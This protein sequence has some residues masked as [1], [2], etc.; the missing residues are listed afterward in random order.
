M[1]VNQVSSLSRI[2]NK[3]EA[4]DFLRNTLKS[5][6]PVAIWRLPNQN[7]VHALIDLSLE[8]CV[9]DSELESI[10]QSFI[11][12]SYHDSHPTKAIV[13]KGHILISISENEAQSE[14]S[15]TL[16]DTQIER[17]EKALNHTVL[18]TTH[19]LKDGNHPDFEHMVADAV[20]KIKDGSL[21]KVVLSRY[22]DFKLKESF[23]PISTFID[24]TETYA[25]AFCHLTSTKS[26]G[27]WLGASPEKLIAIESDQYFSTDALAGTQPL[28][29]GK[30]LCDVAWTQKEIEEQA[31][32]SRYI[33]DCFKKIR[34]REFD[35]N[36][37]KTIKA[38]NL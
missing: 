23:D 29:A 16:T 2:S 1:N 4:C 17:F 3:N 9:M 21:H 15:P 14:L 12:N 38:G 34:L 35:E 36:G 31:M 22:Q 24:L 33:I 7:K 13:L 18:D 28:P 8:E 25:N 10:D 30:E 27:L 5:A 32:V 6:Y 20:T 11:I 37:P 26:H 19:Q